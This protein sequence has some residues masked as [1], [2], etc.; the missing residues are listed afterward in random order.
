MKKGTTIILIVVAFVAGVLFANLIPTSHAIETDSIDRTPA[1]LYP[2]D[3]Y[4]TARKVQMFID[5]K[6]YHHHAS[7]PFIIGKEKGKAFIV[8]R[9]EAIDRGFLPCPNC[10][11]EDVNMK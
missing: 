11:Y 2:L 1:V 6:Y 4:P 5:D 9:Y 10:V 8:S 7:C 3:Q